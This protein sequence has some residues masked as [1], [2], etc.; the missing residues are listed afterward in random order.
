MN[1]KMLF[2]FVAGVITG[3]AGTWY[4]MN[5]KYYAPVEEPEIEPDDDYEDGIRTEPR[6]DSDEDETDEA[7]RV[8]YEKVAGQ[9]TEKEEEKPGAYVIDRSDYNDGT[10]PTHV[11]W[12]YFEDGV[13]EDEYNQI[14]E[15]A[16]AEEALGMTAKEL[17]EMFE[18]NEDDLIYIR[19]KA[20][21]CDYEIQREG[22]TYHDPEEE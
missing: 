2:T 10:V 8:E 18:K 20:R 6:P 13:I 22:V 19:N 3:A 12:S 1:A 4:Y 7:A 17:A 9:Y 16:D 14:I 5:K 11:S 15:P 21:Y